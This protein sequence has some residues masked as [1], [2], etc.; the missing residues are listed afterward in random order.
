M[1]ADQLNNEGPRNV[2][3]TFKVLALTC[4]VLSCQG[5]F[6]DSLSSAFSSIGDAF[7]DTAQQLGEQAKTVG[8]GLLD[9]LKTQSTQLASQ[10]LQSLLMG[11]MNALSQSSTATKRDVQQIVGQYGALKNE[12]QQAIVERIGNLQGM[13]NEAIS[14]ME[15]SFSKLTHVPVSQIEAEIKH[16]VQTHEGLSNLLIQDLTN[17]LVNVFGK[18]FPKTNKRNVITDALGSIANATAAFF[19]PHVDAVNQLVSGVGSAL[20]Q[21]AST[22]TSALQTSP[23]STEV[24]NSG[25]AILQHGSSALSALQQSVTDILQN[26]LTNIQPHLVN[27]I[28][29]GASA[30]TESLATSLSGATNPEP[31]S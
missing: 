25:Q 23:H 1:G 28:Q 3:K 17:N 12:A 7:T 2:M 15:Q 26:T 13:L 5:S 31:S 19:K 8:Q 22:F 30:L 6:L 27:I 18:A 24:T 10:A 4:L 20:T 29:H 11:S 21:T 9:Q 14:K 16:I